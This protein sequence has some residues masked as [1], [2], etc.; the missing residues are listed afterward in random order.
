[1]EG[2]I[3]LAAVVMQQ[4]KEATVPSQDIIWTITPCKNSQNVFTP[5]FLY[6]LNKQDTI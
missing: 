3:L 6:W 4:L 1:M 5:L 2:Y